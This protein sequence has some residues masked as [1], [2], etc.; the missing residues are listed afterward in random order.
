MKPGQLIAH[1]AFECHDN[2][3]ARS[4][5]WI[6]NIPIPTYMFLPPVFTVAD[7]DALI[8]AV[9]R[10]LPVLTYLRPVSVI[11]PR[12]DDW[13]D[14][15]ATL[16]RR[17]PVSVTR[18][19]HEAGLAPATVSRGF[20]A[21]FGVTPGRYRLESQLLRAMQLIATTDESLAA[22]AD[23]CGFADQ[24][25]LCRTVRVAS[26]YSPREWKVKSIQDDRM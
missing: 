20:L 17:K 6:I 2:E 15:L 1:A 22:I 14:T 10:G 26:G 18:W 16:L 13:P 12:D 25:H 7:P 24:A 21:A 3:I 4:G 23:S 19:A 5:A 9:R 11:S 8:I